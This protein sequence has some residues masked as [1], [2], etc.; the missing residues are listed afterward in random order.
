M[1]DANGLLKKIVD[2]FVR[3]H[4]LNLL[5]RVGLGH[6]SGGAFLS[7]LQQRLKLQSMALY[8]SP[9][10]YGD[11]HS[12]NDALIPTLYLTM[13]NDGSV[14]NRMNDNT[15]RLQ[16]RNITSYLYKVSPKPFTQKLCAARLPELKKG[17]CE[18][19]FATIRKQKPHSSLLDADGFV[20]DENAAS[21]KWLDL[22]EFLELDYEGF[23]PI[24]NTE[25]LQ[26]YDDEKPKCW[27]RTV[28][29]QEIKTCYG[30]HAMTSQYHDEIINFLISNS[31]KNPVR[32]QD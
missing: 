20:L 32:S 25:G 1:E 8:N 24:D 10:D 29:E 7:F 13:S 9:E 28:L 17:F 30:Y 3:R 6:S 15:K 2:Q 22:F 31:K 26:Y 21:T 18:H 12:R 23:C 19:M 5:P 14:M 4:K 27:M 11:M 16:D